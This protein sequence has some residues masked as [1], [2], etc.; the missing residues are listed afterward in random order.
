MI[1]F[2]IMNRRYP[3][4]RQCVDFPQARR[5]PGDISF[6]VIPRVVRAMPRQFAHD[7]LLY[8]AQR[9]AEVNHEVFLLSL[10]MSFQIFTLTPF[11]SQL[12]SNR[13]FSNSN[14]SKIIIIMNMKTSVPK[15]SP[16]SK[17]SKSVKVPK[18]TL[19]PKP[20][21]SSSFSSNSNSDN[22]KRVV[23]ANKTKQ[24]TLSQRISAMPAT[25]RTH[26]A[27]VS[28]PAVIVTE[29]AP[30][31]TTTAPIT[32]APA[33]PSTFTSKSATTTHTNTNTPMRSIWYLGGNQLVQLLTSVDGDLDH[34]ML[35]NIAEVPSVIGDL[36]LSVESLVSDDHA[37]V[38]GFESALLAQITSNTLAAKWISSSSSSTTTP[39]APVAAPQQ[40][41]Q[42]Q[43]TAAPPQ[44]AVPMPVP[45]V[46]NNNSDDTSSCH[47]VEV[48]H[49]H[50]QTATSDA[51]PNPLAPYQP[52]P[53]PLA[54]I[55]PPASPLTM[56]S[57]GSSDDNNNDNNKRKESPSSF[58]P[59]AAKMIKSR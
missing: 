7:A 13:P 59:A 25:T 30:R 23:L 45:V 34:A 20:S 31:A 54:R 22:N 53:N 9:P 3:G 26:A 51:V 8:C 49:Y 4:I 46:T 27:I 6:A 42:Q 55:T 36:A 19:K 1:D 48:E 52:V 2:Y 39:E 15:Q 41:Q 40:E 35:A 33:D 37:T 44:T 29:L 18:T 16:K 58:V 43:A 5:K 21:S 11:L 24:S 28:K 56:S 50:H 57:S 47:S 32:G 17:T 14:H 10:C 38:G 12:F